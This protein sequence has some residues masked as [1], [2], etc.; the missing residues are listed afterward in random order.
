MRGKSK[1][2]LG[3]I[4]G[5]MIFGSLTAVASGIIANPTTSKVFVNGIEVEAE[6]YNVNDNNY[7]KIRDIAEAL[8][9]CITWDAE[10]DQIRIDTTRTYGQEETAP[11]VSEEELF[12]AQVA[13]FTAEVVRLT[14][15]ERQNAGLR[16]LQVG[17]HLM[18]MALVK[19]NDMAEYLYVNH[20]SPVFGMTKN[21]VNSSSWGFVGENVAGGQ[22]NPEEVI[23]GWMASPSHKVNLMNPSAT[24]IGVGIALTDNGTLVWTQIFA[25]KK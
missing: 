11:V 10:N 25:T 8:N 3:F 6:A 5:A 18:D 4:I 16:P 2:I 24:H 1:F 22:K 23:E 19:S 9:F 17:A 14:N 12:A 20:V 7:F 13:E 21:I 15:V